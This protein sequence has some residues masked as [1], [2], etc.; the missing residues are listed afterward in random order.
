M[1]HQKYPLEWCG[2]NTDDDSKDNGVINFATDDDGF[3][4]VTPIIN[5]MISKKSSPMIDEEA[6]AGAGEEDSRI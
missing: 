2:L 1:L 4:V 6:D 3:F 5:A